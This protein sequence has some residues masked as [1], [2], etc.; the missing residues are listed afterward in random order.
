VD[1]T[2]E[3][4]T[5]LLKLVAIVGAIPIVDKDGTT[6]IAALNVMDGDTFENDPRWT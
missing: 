5:A 6:V 3:S 1:L 4:P 2:S